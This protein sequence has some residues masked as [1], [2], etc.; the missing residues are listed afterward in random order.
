MIKGKL[1]HP[2]ILEALAQ[3]GHFSQVLIADGN[4]PAG[5][6]RGPNAKVVF[7]NF[8]PG[9]VDA[10]TV[11]RVLLDT[12]PVQAATVMQP[13]ADFHPE[14]HDL[15]RQLLGENVPWNHMERWPFYDKI[16]SPN[17][18]LVIATGERRRFA[19]L[20]LEVGVVK[21]PEESF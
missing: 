9:T 3:S 15:Y 5:S 13:P 20:L 19:N 21:L 8:T 17:T 16:K 4:F 10:I 11:L 6:L 14:I 1:I 2:E 7:L 12:I 18:T